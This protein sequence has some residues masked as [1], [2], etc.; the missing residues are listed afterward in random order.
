MF[1]FKVWFIQSRWLWN[2]K[3]ARV[4]ATK[5]QQKLSTGTKTSVLDNFNVYLNNINFYCLG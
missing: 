4:R 2:K 3:T 1:S 5:S